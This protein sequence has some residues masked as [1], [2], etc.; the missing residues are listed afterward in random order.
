MHFASVGNELDWT[1]MYWDFLTAQGG[2]FAKYMQAEVNVGSTWPA[3]GTKPSN[4]SANHFDL[5]RAQLNLLDSVQGAK[6]LA[7]ARGNLFD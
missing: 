6:F 5:I 7:A 3:N 4:P 2:N 1:K